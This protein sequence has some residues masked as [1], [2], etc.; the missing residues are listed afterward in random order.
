MEAKNLL[1][2]LFSPRKFAFS[3]SP[4][5]DSEPEKDGEIL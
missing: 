2:K 3:C 5:T 1:E 4:K